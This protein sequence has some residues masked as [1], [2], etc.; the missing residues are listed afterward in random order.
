MTFVLFALILLLVF[1][2][3][4]QVYAAANFTSSPTNQMVKVLIEKA[5]ISLNNGH[6]QNALSNLTLADRLL[7]GS[8]Y[9]GAPQVVR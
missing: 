8:V 9:S 7:G 2:S 1:I 5:I 6:A 3:E 4:Q